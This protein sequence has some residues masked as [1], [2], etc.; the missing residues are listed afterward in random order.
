M[1]DDLRRE[2]VESTRELIARTPDGLTATVLEEFG[3]DDVLA[4][5]PEEAVASMFQ[6]IGSAASASAALDL[7]ILRAAPALAEFGP[8]TV[9]RLAA[10]PEPLIPGASIELRGYLTAC[11]AAAPATAVAWHPAADTVAVL[12]LPGSGTEVDDVAGVDPSKRLRTIVAPQARVWEICDG[13]TASA[14]RHSIMRANA[15]EQLGVARAILA[16]AAEHVRERRQFG[17]QIGA[18]QAVQHRLADVFVAA[19]SAQ[20]A[21]DASWSAAADIAVPT[22]ALLAARTAALAVQHGL[23]VCGGMGFTEEFSFAA[24]IR[25]SVLLADLYWSEGELAHTIGERIGA[26]GTLPR[27]AASVGAG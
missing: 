12:D 2:L 24:Q 19:E 20:E 11:G 14:I 6:E 17:Q 13:A 15:Y 23:Q 27:L 3:W 7:V 1:D 21:L 22:A 16:V 9:C 26:G 5:H 25:R 18:Y 4:E 10:V 8:F